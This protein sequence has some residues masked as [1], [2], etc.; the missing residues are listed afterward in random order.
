MIPYPRAPLQGGHFSASFVA[1]RTRAEEWQ[2]V[3][4]AQVREGIIRVAGAQVSQRV[5]WTGGDRDRAE[6]RGRATGDIG[7]SVA[8]DVHISG[9]KSASELFFGAGQSQRWQFIARL[10]LIAKRANG[11][12]AI[13]SSGGQLP[14]GEPLDV[15]RNQ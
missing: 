12:I 14:P 3:E 10:R 15:A 11:E 6:P 2:L 8:D 9:R 13:E 5:F 7:G 4:V 1:I